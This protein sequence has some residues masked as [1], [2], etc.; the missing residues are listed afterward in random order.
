VTY[1]VSPEVTESETPGF[2]ARFPFNKRPR[3]GGNL[4]A[5]S[6]AALICPTIPE[7]VNNN[8]NMTAKTLLLVG[9]NVATQWVN[10]VA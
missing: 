8:P 1:K 5:D 7:R 2:P 4:F 9:A 6:G 10:R 3:R